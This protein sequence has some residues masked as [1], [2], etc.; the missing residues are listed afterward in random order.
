MR[1]GNSPNDGAVAVDDMNEN[2]S[3]FYVHWYH[4]S[5]MQILSELSSGC[6]EGD[7][8]GLI[9][10]SELDPACEDDTLTLTLF[11][12]QRNLLIVTTLIHDLWRY[13]AHFSFYYR[14]A[15][16]R[17]YLHLIKAVTAV[18]LLRTL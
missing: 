14:P 6:R 11:P 12:E 3:F 15:A 13:D 4:Y 16:P 10:L 7:D 1:I 8:F 2:T 9:Y 17:A 5:V 18:H